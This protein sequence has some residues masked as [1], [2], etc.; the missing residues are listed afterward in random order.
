[1]DKGE[2]FYNHTIDIFYYNL[3][4]DKLNIDSFTLVR[5]RNN[6]K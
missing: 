1:M 3:I 6:I 4:F 5:I 2:T